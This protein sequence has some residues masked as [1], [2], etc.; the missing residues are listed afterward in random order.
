MD[1]CSTIISKSY[2][3]SKGTGEDECINDIAQVP[4]ISKLAS[5]SASAPFEL[6]GSSAVDNDNEFL[7]LPVSFDS[8]CSN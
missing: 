3:D 2:E 8:C 5:A 7:F 1:L 4:H 6:P